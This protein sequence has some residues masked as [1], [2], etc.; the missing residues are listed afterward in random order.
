MSLNLRRR[1]VLYFI[2]FDIDI[3]EYRNC[4]DCILKEME[5][6]ISISMFKKKKKKI[7]TGKFYLILKEQGTLGDP[8]P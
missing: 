3:F 4:A 7:V 5:C 6:I 1:N 8:I 2:L